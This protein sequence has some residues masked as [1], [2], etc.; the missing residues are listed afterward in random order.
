MIQAA[1]RHVR[2]VS[3]GHYLPPQV[4]P[5]TEI[6]QRLGLSPG[7]S[8]RASGVERRHFVTDQSS[9]QMGAYAAM[10]ALENASLRFEDLDLLVCA[11]ATFD[12]PIP[13][14]AALIQRALGKENSGVACFDV[15]STCLSFVTALDTLSYLVD[16]GRYRRVMIVSSEI[17]SIGL[18]W[19]R[20]G[21]E[22]CSL[23]GDGA[24]A[25]IIEKS[26]LLSGVSGGVICGAHME[27][28][29]AGADTCAIRGGGAILPSWKWTDSLYDEYRFSMNGKKV[30][31]LVS[32]KIDG[33]MEKLLQSAGWTLEDA[34]LVIPHQASYSAMELMRRRLGVPEGKWM[35]I[36]QNHGNMIA[37]SIP[38]ALHLAIS[39]NRLKRGDKLLLIGTSAGFSIGGL[40][41]EY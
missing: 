39:E 5:S 33:F 22:A 23:F 11:S 28:Y 38:M 32:E 8:A 30:F 20:G 40:A 26:S 25:V 9:A 35:C 10:S 34:A 31:R 36:I 12:Q 41:L 18:N 24:V 1:N 21:V 29:S 7:S 6:D 4:V 15:G 3:T 2:I 13:Y 27:T 19:K 17:A 37:A 16:A 14:N